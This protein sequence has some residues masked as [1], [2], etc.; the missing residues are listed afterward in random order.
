MRDLFEFE[1]LG[2]IPNCQAVHVHF[3]FSPIWEHVW[4]LEGGAVR[5]EGRLYCRSPSACA[6]NRLLVV[7]GSCGMK[8][9]TAGARSL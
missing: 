2:S 4:D 6:R 8:G 5:A 3:S 7:H 1:A 9:P